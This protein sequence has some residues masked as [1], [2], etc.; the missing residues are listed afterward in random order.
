MFEWCGGYLYRGWLIAYTKG[1]KQATSLQ[2]M[3][4][5]IDENGVKIFLHSNNKSEWVQCMESMLLITCFRKH[6]LEQRFRMGSKIKRTAEKVR[7]Q[8]WL[9]E[10]QR[11][12]RFDR[13]WFSVFGRSSWGLVGAVFFHVEIPNQQFWRNDIPPMRWV[14][15]KSKRIWSQRTPLLTSLRWDNRTNR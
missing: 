9:Y 15:R 1:S 3:A 5:T 8:L 14:S 2:Q 11:K 10:F 13:D 6:Q 12:F 4:G 7:W